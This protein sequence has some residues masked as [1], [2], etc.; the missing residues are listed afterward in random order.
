MKNDHKILMVPVVLI[1]VFSLLYSE[2]HSSSSKK[3]KLPDPVKTSMRF[4]PDRDP[5]SYGN[6]EIEVA[7]KALFEIKSLEITIDHSEGIVFQAKLPDFKGK[8]RAGEKRLWRITGKIIGNENEL[9]RYANMRSKII[10]DVR[11]LFPY[12]GVLI[13]IKNRYMNNE[14]RQKEYINY[15]DLL[16]GRMMNV[17]KT[18]IVQ[19]PEYRD[20]WK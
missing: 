1:F 18:L 5:D 9:H 16:R 17:T 7:C 20:Y 12:E 8:M 10:F 19:K 2:T 4:L 13:F 15:L 6:F 3:I 11:Y 14:V